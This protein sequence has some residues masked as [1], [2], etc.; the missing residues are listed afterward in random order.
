MWQSTRIVLIVGAWVLLIALVWGWGALR[1]KA[2]LSHTTSGLVVYH[3][4][5]R[6]ALAV[7]L[8]LAAIAGWRSGD[9]VGPFVDVLV[10][11]LPVLVIHWVLTKRQSW[12]RGSRRCAAAPRLATPE[13]NGWPSRAA[14]LRAL[15]CGLRGRAY[16]PCQHG[17]RGVTLRRRRLRR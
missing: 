8:A 15:A 7:L 3:A 9:F 12:L 4:L 2:L 10:I 1:R 17:G 13:R 11:L 16:D 14:A 5:G 6:G